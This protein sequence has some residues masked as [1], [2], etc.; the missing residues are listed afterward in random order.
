MLYVCD[1]QISNSQI[2][3]YSLIFFSDIYNLFDGRIKKVVQLDFSGESSTVS[4]VRQISACPNGKMFTILTD[5]QLLA[6]RQKLH[7]LLSDGKSVSD[8][9]LGTENI[10]V[11]TRQPDEYLLFNISSMQQIYC[12]PISPKEVIIFAQH[13]GRTDKC[14]GPDS[15]RDLQEALISDILVNVDVRESLLNIALSSQNLESA[16]QNL[17]IA[18]NGNESEIC[19]MLQVLDD[20]I[21]IS[22]NSSPTHFGLQII[23]LSLGFASRSFK[24]FPHCSVI[25]N[26]IFAWQK[27][28]PLDQPQP[29]SLLAGDEVQALT[30]KLKL[31]NEDEILKYALLHNCLPAGDLSKS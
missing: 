22:Q 28:L 14:L 12:C 4:R 23:G 27:L 25:F 2:L 30:E 10:A 6:G 18:D 15:I 31:M 8:V 16:V 1:F 3:I 13:F 9:R 26:L 7:V 29:S 19:R 11:L 21:Q 24:K 5:T 20:Y 17:K